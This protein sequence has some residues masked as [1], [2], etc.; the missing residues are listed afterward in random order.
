MSLALTCSHVKH[1]Q[2]L[3]FVFL[4]RTVSDFD[5]RGSKPELD[6]CRYVLGSEQS[7]APIAALDLPGSSSTL[8]SIALKLRDARGGNSSKLHVD[9]LPAWDCRHQIDNCISRNNV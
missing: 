8:T 9:F 4:L 7:S 6:V 2:C 3:L 1:S 5:A